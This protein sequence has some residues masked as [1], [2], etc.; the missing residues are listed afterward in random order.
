[1]KN[2]MVKVHLNIWIVSALVDYDD[3]DFNVGS[4]TRLWANI[5]VMGEWGGRRNEGE[6]SGNAATRKNGFGVPTCSRVVCPIPRAHAAHD[7][8]IDHTTV[9]GKTYRSCDGKHITGVGAFVDDRDGS[10]RLVAL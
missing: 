2:W 9:E 8:D 4:S 10:S 5:Q 1:M 3:V 6:T 7:S